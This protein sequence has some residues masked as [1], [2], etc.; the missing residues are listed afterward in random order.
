[1]KALAT[2]VLVVLANAPFQASAEE[3][4][5]WFLKL[6]ANGSEADRQMIETRLSNIQNGFYWANRS[7]A[8]ANRPK[9]YCAPE[10][11]TPTGSQLLECVRLQVK[12]DPRGLLLP[13][14]FVLLISLET[15]YPCK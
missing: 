14:G 2:L 11:L 5:A 13:L 8:L 3:N 1:M 9:L 4:T 12:A 15:M 6:H 10:E 7:M